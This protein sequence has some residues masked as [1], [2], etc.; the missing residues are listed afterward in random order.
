MTTTTDSTDSR[1][2]HGVDSTKVPQAEVYLVLSEEERAK[3]FVRLYRDAYK[4]TGVQPK[5][6]TRELTAEEKERYSQFG[7]VA[8]E[9][10]PESE[11]PLSGRFWTQTQLDTKACNQTTT[12]HRDL[13]ETY[14]RDPKFYGATYC[15]H[16][17]MHRP[18]AEFRW[19]DGAVLGS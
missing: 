11:R 2:T 18:L 19:L 16:C 7:Y 8:F 4:H 1:L 15:C 14:A 17:Q 10:Y 12:M 6:P 13:A 5:G 9:P 3:G